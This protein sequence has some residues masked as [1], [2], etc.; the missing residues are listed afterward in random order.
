MRTA[1]VTLPLLLNARRSG[2]TG[3]TW[4]TRRDDIAAAIRD[5]G[6]ERDLGTAGLESAH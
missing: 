4:V 2:T 3:A 5:I 1:T 6:R